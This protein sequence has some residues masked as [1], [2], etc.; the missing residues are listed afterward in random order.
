METVTLTNRILQKVK[1]FGADDAGV[2]LASDLLSGPTHQKFPLPEGVQNHHFILVFAL[3]H[4]PDRPELDYYIRKDGFRFGN[5][6]G[7]I[8]LM[9]ISE[10]IRQW[11]SSE[12]LISRDLH[13]YV[14]RGGV[15]L[16]GA[17]V[18]A[19]LGTIGV[20][21]LLIHPEYGARIRFRAHLV[22][23]PLVP[24]EPLDFDPCSGCHRPCLE[25]CPEEGLNAAGYLTDRCQNRLDRDFDEGVDLPAVGGN[26]PA[27]EIHCCRACEFACSFMGTREQ[28]HH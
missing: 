11:L 28:L 18:L 24:S 17:A 6:R 27:V 26:P 16:K 8:Q 19:G 7:N 5:S 3:G 22:D 12:G 9:D 2:C 21:N 20:N 10:N 4:P 23:T 25:A 13:Y 14:E 15:F 1:D